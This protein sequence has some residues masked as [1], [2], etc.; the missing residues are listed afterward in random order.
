MDIWKGHNAVDMPSHIK[1]CAK[2]VVARECSTNSPTA[3]FF[4]HAVKLSRPVANMCLELDTTLSLLRHGW[5][6]ADDKNLG[7]PIIGDQDSAWRGGSNSSTSSESTR[8][9]TRATYT[10]TGCTHR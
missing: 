3:P 2:Y 8:S 9:Q 10:S 6:F 7:V 1:T 4:R 5:H